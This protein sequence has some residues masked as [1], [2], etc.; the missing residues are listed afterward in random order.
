MSL[1]LSKTKHKKEQ[2]TT[3]RKNLSWEKKGWTKT[4]ADKSWQQVTRKDKSD[5]KYIEYQEQATAKQKRGQRN[6]EF[7][8]VSQNTHIADRRVGFNHCASREMRDLAGQAEKKQKKTKQQKRTKQNMA[9]EIL[10]S[11]INEKRKMNEGTTWKNFN[12]SKE[13]ETVLQSTRIANRLVAVHHA[14]GRTWPSREK[15]SEKRTKQQ[16]NEEKQNLPTQVPNVTYRIQTKERRT[17]NDTEIKS[18]EQRKMEQFNSL[19]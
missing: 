6:N 4:K 3:Q 16:K 17:K 12:W 15:R 18:S 11:L 1:N 9:T 19:K 13:I 10:K 2:E 8:A 5:I 7:E 14:R